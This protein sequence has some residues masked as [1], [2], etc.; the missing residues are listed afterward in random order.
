MYHDLHQRK[1]SRQEKFLVLLPVLGSVRWCQWLSW[2]II[3][4]D[5]KLSKFRMYLGLFHHSRT[6]LVNKQIASATKLLASTNDSETPCSNLEKC[7]ETLYMYTSYQTSLFLS[8]ENLNCLPKENYRQA[9]ITYVT[10]YAC[11]KSLYT[12]WTIFMYK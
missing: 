5:M 2:S 12:K 3:L 9:P 8:K 1:K 10:C 6:V 7:L 11:R 4:P